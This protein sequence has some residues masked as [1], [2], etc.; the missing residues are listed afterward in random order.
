[1]PERAWG[2]NSPTRTQIEGGY[3]RVLAQSWF[4]HAIASLVVLS[5]G[6]DPRV[7]GVSMIEGS[8]SP[9][10]EAPKVDD[11]ATAEELGDITGGMGPMPA[12][13]GGAFAGTFDVSW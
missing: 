9:E 7:R 6:N 4:S 3:R 11:G 5:D 12:N 10:E 8:T 2:L 1:M 13:E